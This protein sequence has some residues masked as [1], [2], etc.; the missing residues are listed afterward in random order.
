[1]IVRNIKV[2]GSVIHANPRIRPRASCTT[3]TEN[4]SHILFRRI[5]GTS[6][7]S[8]VRISP[9]QHYVVSGGEYFRLCADGIDIEGM[10]RVWSLDND[11]H[12]LKKE[13]ALPPVDEPSRSSALALRS[14]TSCGTARASASPFVETDAVV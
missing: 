2:G 5:V 4:A 10:V 9:N 13:V 14:A 8:V 12:P 3:S 11:E 1:M 7:H 6:S